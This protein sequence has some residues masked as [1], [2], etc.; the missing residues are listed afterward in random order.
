MITARGTGQTTRLL[1]ATPLGGAYIVTH[2]PM[3]TLIE[4]YLTKIDRKYDIMVFSVDE[5]VDQF[6]LKGRNIPVAVD[7]SCFEEG[8]SAIN[9]LM[10]HVHAAPMILTNDFEGDVITTW[11]K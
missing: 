9:R 2:S 11:R 7:H 5:V 3:K 4:Q 10:E 8:H 6:A 1:K